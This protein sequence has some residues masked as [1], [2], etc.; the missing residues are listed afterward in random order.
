MHTSSRFA[1]AIHTLAYLAARNSGEQSITSEMIAQSVNTNAVVIRRVLGTLREAKIVT[2][3]TG[4]GGGWYL[5]RRPEAINLRD[6]YRALE[7]DP[8]FAL[9]PKPGNAHCEIGKNI[10]DILNSYFK[11]AE[12]AAEARLSGVTLAEVMLELWSHVKSSVHGP[13]DVNTVK[14]RHWDKI[15]AR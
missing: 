15:R 6:V 12:R 4:S 9:P 5:K 2:S 3:Q 13:T 14:T 11:E 10:Q 1:V 7:S 8:L